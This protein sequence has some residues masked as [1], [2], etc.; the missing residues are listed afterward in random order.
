MEALNGMSLSEFLH[1]DDDESPEI[2]TKAV[3]S[4]ARSSNE[5]A[6]E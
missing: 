6:Q 1:K 2:C 4:M 5:I 3:G